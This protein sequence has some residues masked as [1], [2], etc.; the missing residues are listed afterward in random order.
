MKHLISE[1]LD[2]VEKAKTKEE[3]IHIFRQYES[4]CLRGLMRINFDETISMKLPEGEPPFKKEKDKPVGVDHNILEHEYKKFYIWLGQNNLTQTKKELLFIQLLEGLH[5]TEAEV[6]CLIKDQHLKYRF[7]SITKK[8]VHEAYP[9]VILGEL[10]K[11]PKVKKD[12]KPDPIEIKVPDDLLDEPVKE[13][14]RRG[15]KP[16]WKKLL[17][18]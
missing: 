13:K 1:I 9:D 12:Y 7:P 18:Q 6:M 2:K 3:K 4:P 8:L 15:P 14:K 5:Y 17:Q 16:G 10:D 11:E